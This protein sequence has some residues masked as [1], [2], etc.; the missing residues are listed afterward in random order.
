V[1]RLVLPLNDAIRVGVI[2]G[3]ADVSDTVSVCES[4]QGGVIGCAIVGDDLLNS[5]PV[6]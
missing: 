1:N 5:F 2:S 4:V 3:D 6:S